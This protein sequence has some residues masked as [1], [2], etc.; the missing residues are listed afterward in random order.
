MSHFI[1]S[2]E[3]TAINSIENSGSKNVEEIDTIELGRPRIVEMP[4]SLESLTI[5]VTLAKTL[6]SNSLSPEEQRRQVNGLVENPAGTNTFD[7][8]EYKGF[9]SVESVDIPREGSR[10]TI[11]QGTIE[12]IFLPESQYKAFVSSI[13]TPPNDFDIRRSGY[14]AFD[15]TVSTPTVSSNNSRSKSIEESVTFGD[16]DLISFPKFIK[17]DAISTVSRDKT[18]L[19]TSSG[20]SGTISEV[21]EGKYRL[22]LRSTGNSVTISNKNGDTLHNLTIDGHYSEEFFLDT[23]RD[24]KVQSPDE[25]DGIALIP[26]FV[27]RIGV[28]HEDF[29]NS[30]RDRGV[31]VSDNGKRINSR[32]Q[33]VND[34]L[35]NN[36]I[37]TF[38]P[39]TGT[40]NGTGPKATITIPDIYSLSGVGSRMVEIGST[41][42]D[43]YVKRGYPMV[44]M[45]GQ[46][47]ATT[48]DVAGADFITGVE[49]DGTYNNTDN[50]VVAIDGAG[51]LVV[52]VN[53]ENSLAISN[54]QISVSAVQVLSLGYSNVGNLVDTT[55]DGDSHTVSIPQGTYIAFGESANT[56][57]LSVEDQSGNSLIIGTQQDSGAYSSTE[58]E[59]DVS[60]DV[61]IS[62]DAGV[63]TLGLIPISLYDRIGVQ[64]VAHKSMSVT[65]QKQGVLERD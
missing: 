16:T 34:P 49:A 55:A 13:S 60:E 23:Q 3:I 2:T 42:Y 37:L 59:V 22:F 19:Y 5:N 24:V 41:G 57:N 7:Y 63:D 40:I 44:E 54:G 38:E 26:R 62:S 9:L 4:S 51:C 36:G 6:H 58:V 39:E 45:E 50:W 8:M 47:P 46:V 56:I 65:K 43:I 64:D 48:V 53:R 17:D 14:V 52:A 33:G 30:E 29:L 28:T 15:P 32:K 12:A 20:F 25:I 21:A 31:I 35:I 10:P 61:T 18:A 27:P 11:A 1:G